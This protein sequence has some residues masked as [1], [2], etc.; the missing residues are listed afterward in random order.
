MSRRTDAERLTRFLQAYADYVRKKLEP[1]NASLRGVLR[2]IKKADNWPTYVATSKA[3]P[4]PI[5]R[6]ETRIKRPESVVDKILRHEQLFNAG[7][8]P[9][10]FK[11]MPDTVGGRI[12][13]F[14]LSHLPL[15]DNA[16]R[17]NPRLQICETK[18]NQPVAYLRSDVKRR[19]GLTHLQ[20]RDKPSG[21]SSLHYVAR[22]KIQEP[23]RGWSPWFEI[24]VRTLAE[25]VW[26]EIEHQL[27]YK[28]RKR[29][30]LEVRRQ[31]TVLGSHLSAIDE[32]FNLLYE[33]QQRLR[34]E[35]AEEEI[36][37]GAL[38]N[39]ENLPSLLGEF[40]LRCRQD[41][42]DGL[43]KVLFSRGIDVARRLRKAASTDHL[44]IIRNTYRARE[45]REPNTFE[46]VANLANLI[47]CNEHEDDVALVEAQIQYLKVWREIQDTRGSRGREGPKRRVP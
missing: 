21:Y 3:T 31:F 45:Q 8:A 17:T 13:V 46:V 5:Q 19:L 20:Q 30:S 43:L 25:D 32:H 18:P 39:A 29:T 34:D 37:D 12:V 9:D 42:I 23:F 47:D 14:V 6:I 11:K 1:T 15:V 26:A 36:K 24:Q 2:E 7:L 16:L 28:P 10:S 35:E 4:T 41:E 27:G 22:L 33:L 40:D 44:D 38:L